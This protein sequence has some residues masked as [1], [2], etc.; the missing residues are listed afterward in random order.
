MNKFLILLI[1]IFLNLFVIGD[2]YKYVCK[3]PIPSEI[4]SSVEAKFINSDDYYDVEK[5]TC[6]MNFWT[7]ETIDDTCTEQRNLEYCRTP[8]DTFV[9]EKINKDLWIAEERCNGG[10]TKLGEIKFEDEILIQKFEE[11]FES[12]QLN[13]LDYEEEVHLTE[14]RF[15]YQIKSQIF[16]TSRLFPHP[17]LSLKIIDEVV[18]VTIQDFPEPRDP[19]LAKPTYKT[20]C[21]IAKN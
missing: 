7:G 1:G 9:I 6:N 4:V 21:E 13:S 14:E 5:R 2:S 19:L 15:L 10:L 17:L 18:E 20:I 8:S 3:A 16:N 11:Y 12:D